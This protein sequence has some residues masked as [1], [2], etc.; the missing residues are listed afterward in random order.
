MEPTGTY[1]RAYWNLWLAA[2]SNPTNINQ[3]QPTRSQMPPP[4]SGR[5][6]WPGNRDKHDIGAPL[7]NRGHPWI[8]RKARMGISHP[9][10][11]TTFVVSTPFFSEKSS[12]PTSRQQFL[13]VKVL[14]VCRETT[15][16]IG[17]CEQKNTGDFP[18][19]DMLSWS[20]GSCKN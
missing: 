6:L 8:F 5:S 12:G 15:I 11:Y 2:P 7:K 16:S 3:H 9:A 4:P 19:V 18:T 1:K 14:L 10:I 20:L 17:S 13:E